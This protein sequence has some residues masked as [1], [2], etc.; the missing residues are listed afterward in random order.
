MALLRYKSD[1]QSSSSRRSSFS[2]SMASKDKAPPPLRSRP[3]PD[4]PP[5][6]IPPIPFESFTLT[7]PP[8]PQT[9]QMR[10]SPSFFKS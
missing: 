3:P 10:P 5:F 8:E 4:P 7:E 1:A 6:T 2:S 9:L